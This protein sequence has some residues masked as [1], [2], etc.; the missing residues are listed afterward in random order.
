[1]L[2]ALRTRRWIGVGLATSLIVPPAMSPG[3]ALGATIS[4]CVRK[5]DPGGDPGQSVAPTE[6]LLSPRTFHA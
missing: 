1:M 3:L 6:V 2:G 5:G 4:A